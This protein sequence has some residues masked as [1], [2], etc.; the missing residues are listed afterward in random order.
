M[1][2]ARVAEGFIDFEIP[3]LGKATKTWYK[4][5]GELKPDVRPL[6]A[7]H[8]GP[9]IYSGYLE[10][11]SDVTKGRPGPL[12]VY[13]QIGNGRSTHLPEKEGDTTFWTEDLFLGELNNLITKLGIREYDLFGHSW[14]GMLGAR[15]ASHQPPGLKHLVLMSTPASMPLWVAGVNSLRD[16]LPREIQDA[17]DK[18][19]KNGTEDSQEYQDAVAFF[20][21]RHLIRIDPIPEAIAKG[22]EWIAT[23]PTVYL[24]M[25]GPNEFTITGSLKTW[26]IINKI[27]KIAVPTLV[28]TGGYDEAVDTTVAPFLE[29]LPQGKWVK[30][31]VCTR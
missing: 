18:G 28:T 7:L 3:A 5:I 10:I 8:G 25:N 20:Y 9:G 15:H 6:I 23:D 4:I 11:L 17:L 21:S 27:H 31:Q 14:G 30:F 19:E 12:I 16:K 1:A 29:K 13:D 24:T 22:F 26:T 2:P